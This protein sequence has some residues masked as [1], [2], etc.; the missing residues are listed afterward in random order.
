MPPHNERSI[1]INQQSRD[2]EAR[3]AIDVVS[4]SDHISGVKKKDDSFLLQ[5]GE[6]GG[7]NVSALNTV[8][9]GLPGSTVTKTMTISNSCCI[10]GVKFLSDSDDVLVDI[11]NNR[12]TVTFIG[13]QFEK[14][15]Q[16]VPTFI[17]VKDGANV[18]FVGCSFYPAVNVGGNIISGP[19]VAANIQLFSCS[20]ITGQ[21]LGTCTETGTTT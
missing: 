3:D 6:H 13:C 2:Q 19:T 5:S 12:C 21:S 17:Q 15:P 11:T 16:S 4:T 8:I 14:N 9:G 10:T 1:H 20:N 7:A 18:H